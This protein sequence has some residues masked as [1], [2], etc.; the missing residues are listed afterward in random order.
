MV[1]DLAAPGLSWGTQDLHRITAHGL[2]SH[3]NGLS[4]CAECGILVS[5]PGIKPTSPCIARWILNH[6]TTREVPRSS[7]LNICWKNEIEGCMK[8]SGLPFFQFLLFLQ[9]SQSH[10][11][12]LHSLDRPVTV[13]KVN[14]TTS[15]LPWTL[16]LSF[17]KKG[18]S[19][20]PYL[21]ILII[22]MA[23]WVIS[24]ENMVHSF[25]LISQKHQGI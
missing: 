23:V 6:W 2:S 22:I 11:L 20:V 14:Y 21:P 1:I 17:L 9:F 4:G 7:F 15:V 3:P 16:K 25:T 8:L 24:Q 12:R 13:I 19:T 18:L 5:H 10:W